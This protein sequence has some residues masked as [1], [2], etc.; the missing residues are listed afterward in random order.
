MLAPLVVGRE[1]GRV[2]GLSD[3][4]LA[5]LLQGVGTLAVGTD[6][7]HQMHLGCL[8]EEAKGEKVAEVVFVCGDEV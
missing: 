4:A 2:G 3:L 5:N 1:A 6:A 7:A 8:C